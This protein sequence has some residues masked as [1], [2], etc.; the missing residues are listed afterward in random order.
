M[1]KSPGPQGSGFLPSIRPMLRRPIAFAAALFATAAAGPAAHGSEIVVVASIKPVHSIVSA[2][3]GDVGTP[4]L[5][6][7]DALS[8]H[9]V[10]LRPSDAAV[11]Q[12]ARIVFLID[13]AMEAGLAAATDTLAPDAQIIELTGAREGR[14]RWRLREGGAFEED[15]QHSHAG[16]DDHG[17]DDHDDEHAEEHGHE[18]DHGL[19]T[20]E[21]EGTGPFDLHIWLDPVNAEG[22]AH[23]IADTLSAAD[24]G[25][26]ERYEENA[27]DFI[28]RLSEL[29]REI[30]TDLTEVKG[31]PF[32]VFHDGYQYFERRFGL[33]AVG[34]AVVSA[35][36]SPGIRRIRE[37]RERIGELGVDCV[38]AEPALDGRLVNTIIEGTSA[39][40]AAVDS[41]GGMIDAGPQLYFTLLRNMADSFRNCLAP[42][43]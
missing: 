14:V 37:I 9:G 5:I 4:H 38:I 23:L 19:V 29:S 34:S 17:H 30:A 6:M 18:D 13:E 28:H 42:S 32:I 1:A 27:H 24:P 26:S 10:Q 20:Y 15:P 31:R 8:H 16:D 25:N 41:I 39:R 36:H 2:V 3:M 22:T 43:G 21:E 12:E 35:E 11:L 33:T 40:A 7:R